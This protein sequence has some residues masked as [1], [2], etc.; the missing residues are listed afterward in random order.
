MNTDKFKRGLEAEKKTLEEEL[1]KVATQDPNNP[2]NWEAAPATR[3]ASEADENIT[4]DSIE[5]YEENIAITNT[6]EKRLQEVNIALSNI[7]SGN[8]GK[9][10]VCEKDIEE[11]RLE[12]NPAARTCKEHMN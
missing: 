10:E 9:C 6:L 11:D 4:A 3:D 2:E 1:S 5:D 7:E 8:Y 12:A